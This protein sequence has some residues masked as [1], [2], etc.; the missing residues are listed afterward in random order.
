VSPTQE[1]DPL[2]VSLGDG[3]FALPGFVTPIRL[4]QLGS[5]AYVPDIKEMHAVTATL[6]SLL[7]VKTLLDDH[8]EP[9]KSPV[10]SVTYPAWGEIYYGP[11]YN[12][13]QKRYVVVS[14]NQHNQITGRAIVVR[15]TSKPNRGRARSSNSALFPVIEDGKAHACCPD[16][17]TL[18][19]RELKLLPANRPT[20]QALPMADMTVVAR[21]LDLAL[22]LTR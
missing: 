21:S 8:P 11:A 16:V 15:T 1:L 22:A 7:V 18:P 9:P 10:G 12:G 3:T 4:D 13:Q 5:Q 2:S 14:H 6:T 19:Q 20:P 17:R